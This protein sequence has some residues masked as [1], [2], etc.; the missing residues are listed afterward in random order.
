MGYLGY[1]ID[2][3]GVRPN[4]KKMISVKEFPVLKT[5]KNFKQFLGLAGY[6]RF[7]EGFSKI[8]NS[9]NQLLTKD[10]LFIWTDKQQIALDILKWKLCEEPLLQ[11]PDFFQPFILTTDASGYAIGGILSQGKIGKDKPIAYASRSSGDTEKKYDTYE[12][13]ALA[14]IFCVTHF[15]PY[16][17][18]RKFT[19]VTDHKPLVCFQNSKYPCSQVSRWRLK[20]AEY[21]FDVVYKAGKMNDKAYALSRNPFVNEEK[22][23]NLH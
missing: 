6:R 22:W 23:R 19:L 16:L 5:Q 18:G 9:L 2:R 10:T 7:I 21:D 17:Y 13:E 8:A 20:L 15:R 3:N 11:R 4:P 14:I 1:I 12:K